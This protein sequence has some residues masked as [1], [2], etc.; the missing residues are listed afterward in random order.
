VS[1]SRPR[2]LGR[3]ARLLWGGLG[4]VLLVFLG[5][6]FL[7]SGSALEDAEADA[8]D[9]AQGLAASVLFTALTPDLVS[10]DILGPDYRDLLIRVQAGIL[11]DERVVQVR[12]WRPDGDL[13][14]STAQ[15]D[16]IDEF[17]A[18]DDPNLE[19]AAGGETVSAI[20]EATV[21]PR[22]G[23]QGSDEKL[24]Q[25]YVPLQPPDGTEVTAV[26][27][28]DQRYAAIEDEANRLWRPIQIGLIVPLGIVVVL[29]GLSLRARAETET[30]PA[31][32]DVRRDERKLRDAESRATAAERAAREVEERLA[33]AERRL[34]DAATSEVPPDA[35]SRMD[36][37]ELKL[38]AEVAEREQFAGEVQRLRTSLAEREAE[39]ARIRDATPP[40]GEPVEPEGIR[41]LIASTERRA[42][43]AEARLADA[44]SEASR[45]VR[46]ATA[47][48]GAAETRATQAEARTT[49]AEA[50][51][52]AAETTVS[53]LRTSLAETESRIAASDAAVA[54]AEERLAAAEAKLV[55]AAGQVE[56]SSPPAR[57][58][59]RAAKVEGEAEEKARELEA[60]LDDLEAKRRSE[61]GELQRAQESY[62]NTQVEL[63]EMQAKLKAAEERVRELESGGPS[64]RAEGAEPAGVAASSGPEPRGED[65]SA[66][67]FGS[68][69]SR[70][71]SLR[72]EVESQIP[73]P[74]APGEA[75]PEEALSLRERLAR[76][77]AARHRVGGSDEE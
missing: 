1:E 7:V 26:V 63:R 9:R 49:E 75:L 67:E 8:E 69:A 12:V 28:I 48:A 17:V 43:E 45:Q 35:A 51:A 13:I 19:L 25:T 76:A 37:L 6:S 44:T 47:L 73:E 61:V 36:E 40:T 56:A 62:A 5:F 33:E 72:Q 31:S 59:S 21:S 53:D 42:E 55:E 30:E 18:Q 66:L 16:A 39:L 29:F 15:R 3:A 50:R 54:S 2:Y 57:A 64:W 27:Q 46:E 23:L 52:E 14:F 10:G 22:Q 24:Y 38:R 20:V 60:R 58:R 34:K 68:F 41:E 11:T 70:L 4:V 71:S 77:A 32:R 65:E 74:D